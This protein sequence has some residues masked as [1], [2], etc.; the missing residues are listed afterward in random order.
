MAMVLAARKAATSA[1]SL[2]V[3]S[4]AGSAA[5]AGGLS[6][7]SDGGASDSLEV[8]G[9]QPPLDE[10]RTLARARTT[11]VNGTVIGMV[12][13]I[14]VLS[15]TGESIG[16]VFDNPTPSNVALLLALVGVW[17]GL[18]WLLQRAVDRFR[19]RGEKSDA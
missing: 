8:V 2:S 7:D 14:A 9:V 19:D 5:G 1:A 12:P 18:G 16:K 13:G 15:L 11:R 3:G 17:L 6:V 10:A 4:V